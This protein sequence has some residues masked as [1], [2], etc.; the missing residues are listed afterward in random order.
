MPCASA[1]PFISNKLIVVK[2]YEGWD[3]DDSSPREFFSISDSNAYT[4]AEPE[5][6][7]NDTVKKEQR[8]QPYRPAEIVVQRPPSSAPQAPERLGY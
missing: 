1:S 2:H 4:K 6:I 5:D 8:H 3:P 7:A